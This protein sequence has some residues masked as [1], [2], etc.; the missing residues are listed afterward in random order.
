[1]AKSTN[2]FSLLTLSNSESVRERTCENNLG[3]LFILLGFS[4][5]SRMI[6]EFTK[7]HLQQGSLFFFFSFSLSPYKEQLG[8]LLETMTHMPTCMKRT[9][10]LQFSVDDGIHLEITHFQQV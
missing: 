3:H 5:S 4:V 10:N 9:E 7:T 8:W 6:Y 1:M 2:V